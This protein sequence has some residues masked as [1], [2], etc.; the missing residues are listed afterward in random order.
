MRRHRL[1]AIAPW[2]L[3]LVALVALPACF[4][5][6][7]DDDDIVVPPEEPLS[8]ALEAPLPGEEVSTS[9]TL[10]WRALGDDAELDRFRLLLDNGNPPSAGQDVGLSTT[11]EAAGLTPFASYSWQV[12]A[13]DENGVD[14]AAS[15]VRT[16]VTGGSVVLGEPAAGATDVRLACYFAWGVAKADNGVTYTLELGPSA[17]DLATAYRGPNTWNWVRALEPGATYTWRV[18]AERTGQD[19]DVTDPRQ[20]TTTADVSDPPTLTFFRLE[21]GGG[22]THFA[23]LDT[24]AHGEPFL[25]RWRA[26]TPATANYSHTELAQLDTMPPFDDGV[27]GFQYAY[28]G[29]DGAEPVIWRPR[30]HDE[31]VGDSVAWFGP[32]DDLAFLNDGSGA[33][34]FGSLLTS[35]VHELLVNATDIEGG[36][37]AA[38]DRALRFVVNHDPDTRALDGETGPP[39]HGDPTQYPYYTVFGGPDAGDHPFAAGDAVP[40]GSYVTLKALGWDDPRDMI[41][42][43]D[44]PLRFA[45][46]WEVWTSD[47]DDATPLGSR[48]AHFTP[49]WTAPDPQGFSADTLG[50]LADQP[51]HWRVMVWAIDEHDRA[52]GTPDTLAFTVPIRR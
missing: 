28:T 29:L 22:E 43:P 36:E 21:G 11:Y 14:L 44:Q 34:P 41:D 31:A 5:D 1:L 37:V 45:G 20:F 51:G 18:T 12:I 27:L 35:G 4:G 39:A 7:D 30:R 42:D 47:P 52:D 6:D 2:L 17:D 33:G 40:P 16:F 15:E 49:E 24:V 46:R 38:D 8:V 13:R 9:P 48:P 3:A 26:Q 10:V 50:V 23:D 19:D 25:V 32:V